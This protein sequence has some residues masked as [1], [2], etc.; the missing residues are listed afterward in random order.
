MKKIFI[1]AIM[2]SLTSF[3]FAQRTDANI[4]GH[5]LSNGEHIAFANI[6]IKGTTIGTSTD[7][8]GHYM[9]V[10]LPEG[11]YT[12]CVQAL[13]Y[14]R[15]E[16]KF[17]I[18]RSQTIELDFH[19][20][21]DI[22][23][24]DE[25]VVT[26]NRNEKNRRASTVTVSTLTQRTMEISGSQVISEG[27]NFCSGL[28]MENNCQNCGF[29][30]L[31]MNGMEGP[32][33]QV[34]INSRPIFGG[35][36]GVY[37]LELIP[38][39]MIERIEIV[40]GGGSAM[41]GSSAIGGTVNL[42]LKDPIRN[43]YEFGAS[44]GLIGYD[45]NNPSASAFD[46][47]V[48][49]NT[50]MISSDSKTGLAVYGFSRDRDYYDANGD[51]FSEL[52]EIKNTTIGARFFHRIGHKSKIALDY[53]NINEARRGGNKFSLPLH[54]SDVSEAVQHI[55]NTAA[56]SFD[57]YF[58]H[59]DKLSVYAS[60]QHVNRDSY[61]GAEQSLSDYGNTKDLSYNVGGHYTFVLDNSSLIAG[62]ENTGSLLKDLKLGYP[63]F[64]NAII[65][66]NEI[67]EIPHV[68]NTLVSNQMLNI[69]GAFTQFEHSIDKFRFSL[70]ARFDY[71]NISCR[72]NISDPKSGNVF[73]PRANVMYNFSDNLLTRLSYGKAYRAPQIFDED[74]HIET[75]GSRKV[76][77]RNDPDLIQENSHSLTASFDYNR[78][79]GKSNINFV[80]EAFYT[81]LENAFANEFEYPDENGTVVFRRVNA[82]QG[83]IVRGINIELRVIPDSRFVFSSG[84]TLQQSFYEEE[85]EFDETRFFRT[86]NDYGYLTMEWIP[87]RKISLSSTSVYTG[88]MLV[89]YFGPTI[90]DPDEGALRTSNPFFDMGFRANYTVR[91][92]GASL[93]IFGGVRNVFNSYQNDF[94]IGI[95]R[96]PGYIYGPAQPR[97]IFIGISLGN[98]LL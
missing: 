19:L 73:I 28:R 62:V 37:G 18:K 8:T 4:F 55:V 72:S 31:R 79:I 97:T 68:D 59:K 22:F 23:G 74:L 27:L 71:Y 26:G 80:V 65:I 86:P 21:P 11:S 20:E 82:D 88:K 38:S 60:T 40:R 49:M 12:V 48:R 70:G 10:N 58:R 3:V 61:Y 50:S 93:R 17:E 67:V 94:D 95:D 33:S 83:A 51:G 14:K 92:N 98:A 6:M 32:Y 2:L 57:R 36:M 78:N 52:S 1:A 45:P 25:V 39:N 53:F 42:I 90:A 16:R 91:I 77:Y 56:L 13:G 44:S 75:S 30:Q 54:E 66:A 85:Q 84:F 69:S 76:I 47:T 9:L 96:D 41:Y 34:L 24:L 15:V 35:L 7:E 89:P 43:T 5:V 87:S 46:H 63:D 81:M 64:D 29:N